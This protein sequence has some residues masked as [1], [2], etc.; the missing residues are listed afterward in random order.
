MERAYAPSRAG[1]SRL[2]DAFARTAETARSR[3]VKWQARLKGATGGSGAH[4]G[5]WFEDDALVV[6]SVDR[7]SPAQRTGVKVGMR[8]LQVDG[9]HVDSIRKV[10]GILRRSKDHLAVLT[11]EKDGRAV[12]DINDLEEMLRE[13]HEHRRAKYPDRHEKALWQEIV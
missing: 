4:S 2:R 5:I 6:E 8:L 9:V 10:V 3:K 1:R 13:E 7:D 11:F 12:V